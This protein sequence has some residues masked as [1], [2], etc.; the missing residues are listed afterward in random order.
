MPSCSIQSPSCVSGLGASH[1][2]SMVFTYSMRP[3]FKLVCLNFG[4]LYYRIYLFKLG[5]FDFNLRLDKIK[6]VGGWTVLIKKFI[7]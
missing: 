4:S 7:L 6:R 3:K 1:L 5:D 2:S